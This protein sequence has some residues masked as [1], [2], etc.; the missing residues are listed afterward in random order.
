MSYDVKKYVGSF[1]LWITSYEGDLI[2]NRLYRRR[3]SCGAALLTLRG[4]QL[5]DEPLS[6]HALKPNRS[7]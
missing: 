3:A 5:P 2:I 4:E 7:D 6:I 1:F